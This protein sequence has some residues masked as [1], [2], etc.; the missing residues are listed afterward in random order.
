[1][2]RSSGVTAYFPG[3]GDRRARQRLEVWTLWLMAELAGVAPVDWLV[4]LHGGGGLYHEVAAVIGHDPEAARVPASAP[5][6]LLSTGGR[7]RPG[8]R[9]SRLKRFAQ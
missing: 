1:M 4:E 2:G 3:L 7:E 9:A 5:G 8:I 6:R